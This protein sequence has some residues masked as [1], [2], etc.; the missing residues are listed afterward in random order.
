[1]IYADKIAQIE[2]FTFDSIVELNRS[3]LPIE[4]RVC[5]WRYPGLNHG[6]AVLTT[7][8]QCSAYI[9]AY[10][11][12]H[13]SKINEVLDNIKVD[14]F[15]NNDIQIIDWGCGQG[16]AT[17]CLFDFFNKQNIPIELVKKVV[18]IEPSEMALQRAII[19]VSAYKGNDNEKIVSIKKFLDDVDSDEI[20]SEH[21]ITIHL[22]SNILD[23]SSIDLL[24]LSNVI[25]DNLKGQHYFFC[26]GPL[27]Y[28]NSRIDVFWNYFNEA[29]S[30]FS[31]VHSK[32]QY[33]NDG[34]LLKT[35]NY[36]AKNRVFKVNGDECELI[37]VDYYLPKQF[38]A[39]Y[40][41]DAVRRAL[42]GIEKEKLEGLYQNLSEFEIQTPFD[43]GAS[44]YDDVHPILAVLSNIVTR[45]LPTKRQPF[46]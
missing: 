40:Q 29:D 36:T 25:K 30:I 4:Y 34:R 16:L 26:W 2:N 37:L 6:T 42:S 38:H 43:I 10:G 31:N 24:R 19:H 3:L 39:A 7:E 32:Q 11:S 8:K 14:D 41:L 44:I 35:Y 27:N 15:R 45:G 23:I 21:P 20:K 12:M 28:G 46:P 1:M 22:F 18:L 5:P 9:A 17:V 33:D 13:Q